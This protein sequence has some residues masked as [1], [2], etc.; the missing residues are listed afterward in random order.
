MNV[1]GAAAS[2]VVE[3]IT[4]GYDGRDV[5]SGVSLHSAEGELLGVIGPNGCGKSTLIRGISRVM[6][7]TE[8][9]ILVNQSEVASLRREQLARLVA[10]VPQSPY[11][12]PAFTSFEVV[13]MGRSPHL[14]RFQNE[15]E[16]DV[17][18]AWDAMEA[19][20]TVAL[21]E[22]RIGEISGGERQ[23]VIMARALAQ[24]PS[25]LLLDEPTAHLDVNYQVEIMDLVRRLCH[26]KGLAVLAA[27]HDLNL[28]AQYCDRLVMLHRGKVYR[29]G[30]PSVVITAANIREVYKV[31]VCISSHPLN[32]LPATFVVPGKDGITRESSPSFPGP[33]V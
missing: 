33:S 4:L 11:L 13:L 24:Q 12:P 26:E 30:V 19:T 3:N 17:A 20:A 14:R 16:K 8:G 21:A 10:V 1:K 23:R 5:L 31:D 28:A 2:L 18:V 22:R 9:R 6:P 7:T 25:V 29:E 32:D 27:L 15:S